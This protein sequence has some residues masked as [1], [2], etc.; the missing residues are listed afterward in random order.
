MWEMLMLECMA[1]VLGPLV[2][3]FRRVLW[4]CWLG[5]LS[6][7]Q[8]M[9]YTDSYCRI[10]EKLQAWTAETPSVEELLD[11]VTLYWL[12][13]SFPRAIFPYRQFFGEKPTFFHNEPSLYINKPMGYSWHPKELAPVPKAW[14]ATSG[15][16]VWYKEH[17]QGGHFAAWEVPKV[18]VEDLESFVQ[19]VW[20]TVAPKL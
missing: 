16:L 9:A 6:I 4:L 11:S 5:E 15:N 18:F 1:L 17:S 7:C 20:P 14:V 13:E 2:L 10:G 8:P 19:E 12:T 3:F